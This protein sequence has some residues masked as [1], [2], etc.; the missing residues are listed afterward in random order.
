MQARMRLPPTLS[1]QRQSTSRSCS[2]SPQPSHVLQLV[3][4]HSYVHQC[5]E[6]D[7]SQCQHCWV[8]VAFEHRHLSL[9]LDSARGLAL[10]LRHGDSRVFAGR[11]RRSWSQ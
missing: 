1:T 3:L 5:S 2:T 10:C 11:S 4:C 9:L 7:L 6:Y 8:F